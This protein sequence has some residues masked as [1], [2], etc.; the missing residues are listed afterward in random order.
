[1]LE[2]LDRVAIERLGAL[3]AVQP[4]ER[5]ERLLNPGGRS[6]R[7]GRRA[8]ADALGLDQRTVAPSSAARRAADRPIGRRRPRARPRHRELAAAPVRGPGS[9]LPGHALVHVAQPGI[10]VIGSRVAASAGPGPRIVGHAMIV[11]PVPTDSPS[12]RRRAL[13]RLALPSPS[14]C[15]SAWRA[16]GPRS[17]PRRRTRR[18][19]RRSRRR[20][21]PRRPGLTAGR[22]AAQPPAPSERAPARAAATVPGRDRR[23]VRPGVP[24][25]LAGPPCPG[26]ARWSRSRATSGCPFE[27][28]ACGD[29]LDPLGPLC[30]RTTLLAE[31]LVAT[32]ASGSPGSARTSMRWPAPACS[33]RT[34]FERTTRSVR[35]DSL[36][37]CSSAGSGVPR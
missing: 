35:G 14:C 36:P 34:R 32:A 6:R 23:L 19:R 8:P 25:A 33:S 12:R 29:G 17:D 31:V 2:G 20:R 24:Q 27:P 3:D 13:A 21:D 10:A 37:R 16:S 5:R 26:A 22:A 15:S 1:M 4:A 9:G 30:E 11:E 18:V 7:S 28:T